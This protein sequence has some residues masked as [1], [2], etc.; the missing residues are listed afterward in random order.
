M[1]KTLSPQ[2][3]DALVRAAQQLPPAATHGA[4]KRTVSPC[5]FRQAGLLN[6]EQVRGI[7]TLHEAF[8]RNLAGALGANLRAPLEISLA[9]VE[10]AAFAEF[11][12][13]VPEF[14]YVA[15][16]NIQPPE[17]TAAVRLDLSLVFPMIDLLLGGQ[18]GSEPQ[19]RNLTE[20][21]EGILETVMRRV[22]CELEATWQPVLAAR[23]EFEQRLPHAQIVQLAPPA[24]RVYLL[25]FDV[26]LA[27]AHG[28]L[29]ILLPAV[30]A[31]ALLRK[32]SRQPGYR[33]RRGAGTGNSR[34]RERLAQASFP[35][36]LA[37]PLCPILV[38]DLV[39]LKVGEVLRFSH[40]TSDPAALQ[41]AGRPVA[42]AL[43]IEANNMRAAQVVERVAQQTTE[44]QELR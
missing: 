6:N 32:L 28:Q 17:A 14:S 15:A 25:N 35:V 29:L 40:R 2:D 41:V 4:E 12:Q 43:P 34:V 19:E 42:A 18:G 20:I 27:G 38:Q 9:S 31:S 23:C 39:E 26:Q 30:V 3:I 33:R 13:R 8:A 36:E 7:R 11:L 10:Q 24:E 16:L 21:E 44:E 22:S 1:E 5:D 37:L